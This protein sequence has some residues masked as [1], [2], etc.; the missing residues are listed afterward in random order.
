MKPRSYVP[1]ELERTAMFCPNP[2][3]EWQGV[4]REAIISK[5]DVVR[6]P[7]CGRA[8]ECVTVGGFSVVQVKVHPLS[9]CGIFRGGI[10]PGDRGEGN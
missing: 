4:G 5:G 1:G 3:C 8:L 6:C 9:N 7:R 10:N 2:D